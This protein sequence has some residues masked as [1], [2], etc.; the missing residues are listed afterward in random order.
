MNYCIYLLVYAIPAS[1][2]SCR[3]TNKIMVGIDAKI[4]AKNK[5]GA[6]F[7]P[8]MDILAMIGLIVEVFVKVRPNI[9]SFQDHVN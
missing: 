4:Q 7:R 9:K 1:K 5:A 3:N 2:L 6:L 8:I